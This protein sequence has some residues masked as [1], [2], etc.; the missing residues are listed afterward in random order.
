MVIIVNER[1][2]K[3][4]AAPKTWS[5]LMKPEWKG[6]F[7]MTDPSKSATACLLTYGLLKQFGRDLEKITANAVVTSSSGSTYKGVATGEFA[8]GLTPEYAAQEYVDRPTSNI[9]LP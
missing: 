6:K 8:V 4:L 1:Q 2:P 3:G 7:A 5:D 9:A